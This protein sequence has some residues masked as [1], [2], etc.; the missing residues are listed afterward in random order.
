[1]A[2]DILM[3]VG[4]LCAIM[5]ILLLG[6]VVEVAIVVICHLIDQNKKVKNDENVD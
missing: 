3:L 2:T 1:M 4:W 6:K 5:G